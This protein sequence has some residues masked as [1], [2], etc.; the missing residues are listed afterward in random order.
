MI[1]KVQR[2]FTKRLHGYKNLSYTDRLTKLALPSLELR[3][4]HL[5][6]IYCYKIVFGLIVRTR[7][8]TG[9]VFK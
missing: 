7:H 1:E 9:Y 5:D 3:L 2:R 8:H 6:L 4:L